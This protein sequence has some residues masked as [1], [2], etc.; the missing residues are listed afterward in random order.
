MSATWETTWSVLMGV[1]FESWV[2]AWD[3]QP[4]ESRG[5]LAGVFVNEVKMLRKQM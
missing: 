2:W 4:T 5:W 1:S 3:P